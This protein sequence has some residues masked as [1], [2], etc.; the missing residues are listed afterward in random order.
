MLNK[1]FTAVPI[2]LS[3]ILSLSPLALITVPLLIP[4]IT[5]AHD[6]QKK[7]ELQ[8]F[9]TLR[10]NPSI[11]EE[12][13]QLDA[14]A[15]NDA[16]I[17]RQKQILPMVSDLAIKSELTP[18][19]GNPNGDVTIVE[20]YDYNC[21]FCRKAHATVE[22][23]LA[24]DPNLKVVYREFPILS[25]GSTLAAKASL[26]AF[27]QGK[28]KEFHTAVMSFKTPVSLPLIEKV[29]NDL[30]LDMVRLREDMEGDDVAGHIAMTRELADLG[31]INGTPVFIVGN[32][33]LNGAYPIESFREV[34]AAQRAAKEK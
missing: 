20:F 28:F 18:T 27:K 11:V 17:A 9:E 29:V 15:K 2:Y 4:S 31:E 22:E 21:N 30:N 12:L 33:I 16:M 32:E 13:L 26:A 24:S 7:F 19:A 1:I 34:I 14:Q 10:A 8:L 23:L 6:S 3:F 5:S 25:E